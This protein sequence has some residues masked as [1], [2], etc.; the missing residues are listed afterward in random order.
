M[1]QMRNTALCFFMLIG[2]ASVFAAANAHTAIEKYREG[3]EAEAAGRFLQAVSAYQAS[4]SAGFPGP[5]AALGEAR[6]LAKWGDPDEATARLSKM[7][8]KGF[9]Q[10]QMLE[11]DDVLLALVKT[12]ALAGPYESARIKRFPCEKLGPH[13]DLDFWLGRWDVEAAGVRLGGNTI[14]R[15]AA[16]CALTEA[17][18]SAVG[19]TGSSLNWHD[20]NTGRW[21]QTYI[22]DTGAVSHYTG[23]MVGDAMVLSTPARQFPRRR[24]TLAPQ[25][26]GSVAQTIELLPNEHDEWRTEFA[27]VYRRAATESGARH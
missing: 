4:V 14:T 11:N 24:M 16:G 8:A 20:P 17:W 2:S 25:A 18:Q 6:A 23:G 12:P 7:F 3:R 1:R 9:M 26:D 15:V 10:V 21:N 13:R 22:G 19:E 5:H 27:A